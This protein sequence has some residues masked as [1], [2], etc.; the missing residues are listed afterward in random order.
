M[1]V[2]IPAKAAAIVTPIRSESCQLTCGKSKGVKI[3]GNPSKLRSRIPVIGKRC[4][5]GFLFLSRKNHAVISKQV[6]RRNGWYGLIP[7]K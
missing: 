6:R 3:I 4:S 2:K 5:F 7:N 1:S